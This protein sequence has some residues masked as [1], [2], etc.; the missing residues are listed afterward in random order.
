MLT[1]QAAKCSRFDKVYDREGTIK[2]LRLFLDHPMVSKIFFNDDKL[3]HALGGR[4][5]SMIDHDDHI[6][7]EIWKWSLWA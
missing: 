7:I 2:L 4:V 6:H 3:Q 5:R 1:G